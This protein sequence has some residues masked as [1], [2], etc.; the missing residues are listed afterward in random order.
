VAWRLFTK[1]FDREK[2]RSLAVIEGRSEL[3]A[4]IFATT[5]IIG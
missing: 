5:S 2:A 4:P 3:A 1:G